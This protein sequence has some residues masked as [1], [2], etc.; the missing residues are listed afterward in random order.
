VNAPRDN[1]QSIKHFY[2]LHLLVF[3]VLLSCFAHLWCF[4]EKRNM[5]SF[6]RQGLTLFHAS[7][8]V[9][10][11]TERTSHFPIVQNPMCGLIHTHTSFVFALLLFHDFSLSYPHSIHHSPSTMI[12]CHTNSLEFSFAFTVY[13]V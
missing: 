6:T 11:R 12:T 13:K 7:H 5:F 4:E 3:F 1:K 10:V 9:F 2:F 8:Q